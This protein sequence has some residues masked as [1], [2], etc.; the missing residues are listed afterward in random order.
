MKELEIEGMTCKHCVTAVERAIGTV[1]GA[2]LTEVSIGSAK[3]DGD[4]TALEGIRK[5]IEKE[6]YH[7]ANIR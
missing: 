5:A 6:G 2:K 4:R 1:P 3:V 7:V